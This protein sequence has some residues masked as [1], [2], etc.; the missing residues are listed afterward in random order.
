MEKPTI[1]V[2]VIEFI[3]LLL[4]IVETMFE[5]V[6]SSTLRDPRVPVALCDHIWKRI[7]GSLDYTII[8]AMYT[9][10]LNVTSY[11]LCVLLVVVKAQHS[12]FLTFKMCRIYQFS[13]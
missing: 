2:E 3:I 11:T 10:H 4:F 7:T 5:E 13:R 1:I 8:C 9:M 12:A 6:P